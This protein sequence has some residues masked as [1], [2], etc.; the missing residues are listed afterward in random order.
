MRG[1]G[2]AIVLAI[3]VLGVLAVRAPADDFDFSGNFTYDNDVLQFNF[4]VG[5]PSS[6]TV[7]SSSWLQGDPPAGFD[8]M[9]GIWDAAGNL[10]A[11]QDDGAVVGT[12]LSNGVPYSHGT[13][14]SYYTVA[15]GAGDYIATVTQF[16]NFN[17]GSLLSSGFVRD[18][19]ANRSFTSA[20]GYGGATQTYFNG[21]WDGLDPRTS[22]WEFHLLNV[23]GATV[24]PAVPEPSS[25]VALALG[26]LALLALRRRRA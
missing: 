1:K 19:V 2:I 21:V 13:W 7:F 25:A 14:D 24:Q 8:P 12:T 5:A 22:A 11:F 10:I 17:V 23:A 3:M 6:V 26:G 15:L 18:G 16:D 9:L 20:L 4:T